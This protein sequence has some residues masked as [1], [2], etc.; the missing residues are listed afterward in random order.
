MVRCPYI[1]FLDSMIKKSAQSHVPLML[2]YVMCE[3]K[4]AC[5]HNIFLRATSHICIEMN[6]EEEEQDEIVTFTIG[7]LYLQ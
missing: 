7:M 2:S 5:D 6:K 1:Y 4:T 3:R